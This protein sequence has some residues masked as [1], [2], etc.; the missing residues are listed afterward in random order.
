MARGLIEHANLNPNVLGK[1]HRRGRIDSGRVSEQRIRIV[2]E[3]G[4]ALVLRRVVLELDE[5]TR[6][7]V[8]VI[9]LATNL[10]VKEVHARVVA[11]VYQ[12]RW[13]IEGPSWTRA[14][15]CSAR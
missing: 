10:P 15:C 1:L 9:T 8:T 12:E 3:D 2:G 4:N 14:R 13:L 7:G 5:P 11:K 6:D